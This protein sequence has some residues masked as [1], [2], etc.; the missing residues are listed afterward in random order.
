MRAVGNWH[1]GNES[2]CFP[3]FPRAG[4]AIV[5]RPSSECVPRSTACVC[6]APLTLVTK[7]WLIR[8]A[9]NK[10]IVTL[11]MGHKNSSVSPEVEFEIQ[12]LFPIN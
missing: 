11:S 8:E 4:Q 12:A 6:N 2:D 9:L 3:L 1:H 5:K 10:C 7:P